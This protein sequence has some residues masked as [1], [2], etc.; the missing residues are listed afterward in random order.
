MFVECIHLFT[1]VVRRYIISFA[2]SIILSNELLGNL[3]NFQVKVEL[4]I[5]YLS[6]ITC[7]FYIS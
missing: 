6:C 7:C 3:L 5:K 4:L 2:M 1:H